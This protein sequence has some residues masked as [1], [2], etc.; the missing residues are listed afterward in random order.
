[1]TSLSQKNT[2]K[3]TTEVSTWVVVVSGWQVLH[4]KSISR[5]ADYK[6]RLSNGSITNENALHSRLRF[7]LRASAPLQHRGLPLPGVGVRRH[8]TPYTDVQ[9]CTNVYNG[10]SVVNTHKISR[11]FYLNLKKK[12]IV[13]VI[14][15]L[16]QFSKNHAECEA[17]CSQTISPKNTQKHDRL[18][19]IVKNIRQQ[20]CRFYFLNIVFLK[21]ILSQWV[22]SLPFYRQVAIEPLQIMRSEFLLSKLFF[23]ILCESLSLN[24]QFNCTRLFKLFYCNNYKNFYSG[25]LKMNA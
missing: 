17:G 12:S 3:I 18:Y 19:L 11:C 13:I 21:H 4:R 10:W 1:M 20:F 7:R 5:V 25:L 24:T 14:T 6:R 8:T 15:S 2:E 9:R 22:F 16:L 23:A